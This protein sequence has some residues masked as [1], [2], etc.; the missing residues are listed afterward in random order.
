[1]STSLQKLLQLILQSVTLKVSQSAVL[2]S[3][4]T[5]DVHETVTLQP[6]FFLLS[7][8]GESSATSS[9]VV[10]PERFGQ[11][12]ARA[13]R[14]EERLGK[15]PSFAP[16]S[17]DNRCKKETHVNMNFMHHFY[18]LSFYFIFFQGISTNF[19]SWKT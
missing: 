8:T 17:G 12:E 3:C 11:S 16:T 18:V 2:S 5:S 1:M 13:S 19:F 14:N 9:Y 6:N 7:K 10:V 15:R 4:V